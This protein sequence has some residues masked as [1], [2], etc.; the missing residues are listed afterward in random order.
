G[1]QAEHAA[2]CEV[3]RDKAAL[4]KARRRSPG[5]CAELG[6]DTTSN[7]RRVDPRGSVAGEVVQD[8]VRLSDARRRGAE[9]GVGQIRDVDTKTLQLGGEQGGRLLAVLLARS[10]VG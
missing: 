8:E 7:E 10:Q 2:R 3:L 6:T 5:E 4:G 1:M 9:L